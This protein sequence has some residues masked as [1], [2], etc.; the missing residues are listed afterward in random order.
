MK[1]T[2]LAMLYNYSVEDYL[3]QFKRGAIKIAS[4]HRAYTWTKEYALLFADSLLKNYPISPLGFVQVK[5][6]SDGRYLLCGHQRFL[7]LMLLYNQVF[8]NEKGRRQIAQWYET[9]PSW[10]AL[11][12]LF[13]IGEHIEK[14]NCSFPNQVDGIT[15]PCIV[16]TKYNNAT[17]EEYFAQVK[18]CFSRPNFSGRLISEKEITAMFM[19]QS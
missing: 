9:K 15:I 14:T 7:T 5:N 18:E 12:E 4:F 19:H 1:H 8:P 6:K 3:M 17:Y 2:F 16:F 11:L 10:D 13:E